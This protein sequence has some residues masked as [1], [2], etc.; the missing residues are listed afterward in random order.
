MHIGQQGAAGCADKI[1][2]QKK[3]T[4][5]RLDKYWGAGCRELSQPCSDLRGRGGGVIIPNPGIEQIAQNI[6]AVGLRGMLL[7]KAQEQP[8]GAG[9]LL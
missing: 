3:V 5:P 7:Q 8:D 4:V 2:P 6:E 9:L 1:A